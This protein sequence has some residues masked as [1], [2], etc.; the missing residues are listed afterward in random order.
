MA[1]LHEKSRNVYILLIVLSEAGI[2]AKI[3]NGIILRTKLKCDYKY[4]VQKKLRK[5]VY[6]KIPR[7]ES[8]VLLV[9][10]IGPS[11][12]QLREKSREAWNRF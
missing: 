9:I 10:V 6:S 1:R 3:K 8:A 12:V 2:N 4:F 11:G 5:N 7:N